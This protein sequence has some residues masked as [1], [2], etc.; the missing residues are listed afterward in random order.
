MQTF[1]ALEDTLWLSCGA[2]ALTFVL[3]GEYARQLFGIPTGRCE[4]FGL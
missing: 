3:G 1:F 4:G 2:F